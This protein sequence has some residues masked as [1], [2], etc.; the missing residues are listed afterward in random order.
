MEGGGR[1]EGRCAPAGGAF[2]GLGGGA[3]VEPE[4]VEGGGDDGLA[5]GGALYAGRFVQLLF[6]STRTIASGGTS[7]HGWRPWPCS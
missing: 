4:A 3:C 6:V 2:D 1:A 7:A 5:F